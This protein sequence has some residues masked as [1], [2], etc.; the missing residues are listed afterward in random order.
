MAD[1]KGKDDTN[2]SW[3]LQFHN[4]SKF[5]KSEYDSVDG[6]VIQF[7]SQSNNSLIN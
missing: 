1:L 5:F 3:F 7:R 4:R 2:F 6:K